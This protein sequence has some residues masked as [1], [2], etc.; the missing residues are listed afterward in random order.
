VDHFAQQY[1]VVT[2]D[3]AG[4]GE[5]GQQRETWSMPA[6]GQDV[7]AVVEQLN[8]TQVVLVGHSMAGPVIVE[9][10][11]RMPTRVIGLVGV[12][13]F[14]N[15]EKTWSKEQIEAFVAPFRLNFPAACGAF[16]RS[17]MF[18]PTSGAALVEAIVATMTA[19]PPHV[20]IGAVEALF[21]HAAAV[22][23]GLQA[24]QAPIRTINHEYHPT[25]LESAGHFYDVT[26]IEAAQRY[27]V[28]VAPM[29]G[30]GHFVMLEDPDTFNQLLEETVQPF[31]AAGMEE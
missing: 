1:T 4:H 11:R 9:A 31:L 25:D 5:S 3:L 28:Q 7:V 2:L 22:R 29:L 30:V 24:L 26:D 6:F 23:A 17:N 18:V 19:A 14:R 12:D 27:G 13:T 16:V 15:L 21:S 20:G 8:L 10:A